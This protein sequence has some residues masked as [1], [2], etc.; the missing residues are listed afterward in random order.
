[1]PAVGCVCPAA[2]TVGDADLGVPQVIYKL[3]GNGF[4]P[5]APPHP[6]RRGR[7]PRR[8]AGYPQTSGKGFSPF[9]R[10]PSVGDADLGVPQG[11]LQTSGGRVFTVCPSGCGFGWCSG[12]SGGGLPRSPPLGDLAVPQPLS[13]EIRGFCL[14]E[15]QR[16]TV[17][18]FSQLSWPQLRGFSLFVFFARPG[19]TLAL[20]LLS[21]QGT[22]LTWR[23]CRT[24]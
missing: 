2:H 20:S 9:A 22:A 21:P 14:C 3:R 23:M 8:P 13:R 15:T 10:I 5:F 19:H 4:S 7:R 16:F 12:I 17:R 1:M 11:Y 18:V 24:M 6:L